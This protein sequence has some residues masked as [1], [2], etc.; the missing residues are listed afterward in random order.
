MR[1]RISRWLAQHVHPRVAQTFS[2]AS[3]SIPRRLAQ[4]SLRELHERDAAAIRGDWERVSG[5]IE[6]AMRRL[7][8]QD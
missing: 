2:P 6:R 3:I 7:G 1:N 8:S 4:P 5:D